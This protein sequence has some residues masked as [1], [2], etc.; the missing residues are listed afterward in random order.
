VRNEIEDALGAQIVSNDALSGVD[1]LSGVGYVAK[2]VLAPRLVDGGTGP[3]EI[4]AWA[5]ARG[6]ALLMVSE[7]W[8]PNWQVTVDGEQAELVRANYAFLGVWIPEG[9]HRV[10]FSYVRPWIVWVG[11]AI[12]L[13][14]LILLVAVAAWWRKT[15]LSSHRAA[16]AQW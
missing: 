11:A 16:S 8:Y 15:A 6:P 12:S 1:G 4:E 9:E 2:A 7:S 13:G 3:H 10:E 14:T 5:V